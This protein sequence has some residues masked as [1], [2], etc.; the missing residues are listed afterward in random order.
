[1]YLTVQTLLN[2]PEIVKAVTDRVQALRLDT[3]F[4]KK[5][6]DF[7]ETKSRRC[8]SLVSQLPGYL[9]KTNRTKYTQ[10]PLYSPTSSGHS[11]PISGS[12]QAMPPSSFGCQKSLTL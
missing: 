11:I 3:I 10:P 6:L 4:W 2:D 9:S 5:H 7:E 12:F 8:W 1:M